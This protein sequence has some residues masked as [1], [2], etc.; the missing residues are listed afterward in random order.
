MQSV[1]IYLTEKLREVETKY[2]ETLD[3]LFQVID[4]NITLRQQLD[5]KVM[6]ED[7]QTDV[8]IHDMKETGAGE[9]AYKNIEPLISPLEK[10]NLLK[11]MNRTGTGKTEI[12]K[13][14]KVKSLDDLTQ[15]QYVHCIH[16]LKAKPDMDNSFTL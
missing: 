4:E 3:Y 5:T 16:S 14:C 10:T 11:E 12:F 8:S 2:M 6:Q 15:M 9:M 7:I 1:E 13:Q